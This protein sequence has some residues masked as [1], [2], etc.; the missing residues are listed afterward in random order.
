MRSMQDS[1][2]LNEMHNLIFLSTEHLERVA[3]NSDALPQINSKLEQIRQ[4]TDRL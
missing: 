3:R 4:N 1:T 2:T